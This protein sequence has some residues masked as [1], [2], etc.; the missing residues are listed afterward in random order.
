[1]TSAPAP[2]AAVCGVGL[3]LIAL[4]AT[5][6]GLQPPQVVGRQ[7]PPTEFS[8]ERAL[9][10]LKRV[11]ADEQS[12]PTGSAGNAA[13]CERIV[14]ELQAIGYSCDLHERFACGASGVC[15]TVTNIVARLPGT[16][17]T[18][19]VLLSAHYDSVGAG[20]G[21]ADDGA[22]V[23]AIIETARALKAGQA[24]P[25]DVWFLLND[26]EE[27]GLLGAEAF[28]KEPQFKG[29][30]FAIN[31]EARGTSGSSYLIET[32]A[33]NAA[34]VDQIRRALKRVNGDSLTYEIYKRLPN[35]TDFTVYRRKG[36]QGAGFAIFENAARYHTAA[37]NLANLDPRSLQHHGDIT[38]A[39]ARSFAASTPA[40]SPQADVVFFALFGRWI[41]AWPQT[42]TGILTAIGFI[43]WIALGV[44]LALRSDARVWHL[45]GAALALPLGLGL[46]AV[47]A[48]GLLYLLIFSGVLSGSWSARGQSVEIAFLLLGAGSVAL[49]APWPRRWFGESGTAYGS[50][51]PFAMVALVTAFVLPAGSFLGIAPLLAGG[52]T[53]NIFIRRPQLWSAIVA[54]AAMPV[55]G[56]FF[57]GIYEAAGHEALLATMFLLAVAL[58]PLLVCLGALRVSAL[59]FGW[60]AVIGAAIVTLLAILRPAF[61]AAS[62]ERLSF[63]YVSG[64]QG[65]Q[66]V[67]D[68]ASN[69]L[70][71]SLAANS[72]FKPIPVQIYP[73]SPWRRFV[74]SSGAAL[75]APVLEV[76]RDEQAG[77]GRRRV[78]LRIRSSRGADEVGLIIPRPTGVVTARVQGIAVPPR[79]K[80]SPASTVKAYTLVGPPFE[81]GTF[82]LELAYTGAVTIYYFDASPGLPTELQF[83]AIRD[84]TTSPFGDGDAS[85]AWAAEGLG[86]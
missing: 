10:T 64:P 25:R 51:A 37:D 33:G 48:V 53:G 74:G 39:L 47:V 41:V 58:A 43:L 52:I 30:G 18:P 79:V 81:G 14:H 49:F 21:A 63:V 24:L 6:A 27:L 12:H 34:I 31:L 44:R 57:L 82:E 1:M 55:W 15:A 22:G 4:A 70:P 78:A 40:Q 7:A 86:P 17:A 28:A 60:L 76:L 20:P 68:T 71:A 13:V 59:A 75:Q 77:T 11:L 35:D 46:V 23:A 2:L 69:R 3:V 50:L 56:P 45:A 83:E 32:S 29:I 65:A 84:P 42:Q 61:T 67:A 62:P 66:L 8:A 54:A 72:A 26:G 85:I 38:L 80:P 73:W 5:Y 36:L 9:E 19:A 16:G